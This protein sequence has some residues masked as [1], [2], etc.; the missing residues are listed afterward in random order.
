MASGRLLHGSLTNFNIITNCNAVV[1]CGPRLITLLGLS[2]TPT[3]TAL[4]TIGGVPIVSVV[5]LLTHCWSRVFKNRT[6]DT[7]VMSGF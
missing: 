6:S 3:A 7:T 5:I 4:V 2:L 1:E